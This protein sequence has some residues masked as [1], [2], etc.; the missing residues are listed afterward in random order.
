[1]ESFAYIHSAVAFEDPSPTPQLRSFEPRLSPLATPLMLNLLS[2]ATV[3]ALLLCG[4]SAMA[5]VYSVG[6]RGPGVAELQRA[7]GVPADGVFGPDTEAAVRN[8]QA[9]RGLHVDGVAGPATLGALGIGGG[10]GTTPSEIVFDSSSGG[11]LSSRSIPSNFRGT[12]VVRTPSGNGVNVRDAPNG[13]PVAGIDDGTRVRLNGRQVFAGGRN[14]A[15][16]EG[17]NDGW[18]AAEFLFPV[19]TDPGPGPDPIPPSGVRGAPYVVAV[20]GDSPILLAEVRRLV[21]GA[22][23]DTSPRGNFIHAASFTQRSNAERLSDF[24]RREGLNARVAYRYIF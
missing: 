5:Q 1:M 16:L 17:S 24:L 4:G 7:L 8:F 9:R 10:G 13:T 18:V 6:D 22:F 23:V 12:A 11:G 2:V 20:P 21:P 19:G 14:W 15:Q 3:S